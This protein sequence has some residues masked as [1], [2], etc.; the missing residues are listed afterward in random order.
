VDAAPHAPNATLTHAR[1]RT[2]VAAAPAWAW[3]ASLVAVTA[4]VRWGL[5][6]L[7]EMPTFVPDEYIYSSLARSIGTHGTTSIRGAHVTF[8]ALLQ[9][10]LTSPLWAWTSVGTAY[11]LTKALNAVAMASSIVPV[12]LIARSLGLGRRERAVCA[13]FAALSPSLLFVGY[14]IANPYSFP[15]ALWALLAG[16]RVLEAPTVRRQALFLCGAGLAALASI[17]FALLP[18]VVLVAA[19]VVERGRPRAL[20]AWW[21]T[22]AVL[23]AGAAVVLPRQGSVL[24]YYSNASHAGATLGAHAWGHWMFVNAYLL[25]L[26]AGVAVVPG[27][28]AGVVD[29]VVRGHDR[30]ARA[31]GALFCS[32]VAIL[33]TE[34]ATSEHGSGGR[35]AER[36]LIVVPALVVPAFLLWARRGFPLRALAAAVA[37]LVLGVLPY[38]PLIGYVGG[39]AGQDS[40]LLRAVSYV[41]TVAPGDGSALLAAAASLLLLIGGLVVA[42]PGRT[43]AAVALA[44]S[45]ACTGAV[46]A[47]S[48]VLTARSTHALRAGSGDLGWIDRSGLRHVA[49][50][51][52]DGTAAYESMFAFLWN[53]HAL[54]REL[55]LGRGTRSDAFAATRLVAG[56][57]G[58]LLEHGRPLGTPFVVS[59]RA[60]RIGFAG[61]V[62]RV[63]RN[64]DL[65]LWQAHGTPRVRYLAEGWWDNGRQGSHGR[66]VVW[67]GRTGSTL[68][69][70]FTADPARGEAIELSGAGG[71]ETLALRSGQRRTLTFHLRPSD[72][73][74]TL[75]LHVTRGV[76]FD[77]RAFVGG[78][79]APPVLVPDR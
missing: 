15:L 67:P 55:L 14:V 75:R 44:A 21:P 5:S 39:T 28:V 43:T 58:V 20:L 63:G 52:T 2:R 78:F 38:Q 16:L 10:L 45:L 12:V 30:R 32:L 65:T 50:V 13:L 68:L 11:A 72:R 46:S 48:L 3:I 70:S 9:P 23:A 22:A 18:I 69:L 8:P 31:F 40:P 62:R 49:V 53:P 66:L 19:V 79:V 56:R 51:S 25:T 17:Q 34:A 1:L 59:G 76:F 54:D 26:A 33:F 41:E 42:R 71:S 64:G 7:Q 74:L 6:L 37:V 35:F 57:D 4:G 47:G 73:A 27:A 36:Y 29:A 61:G 77:G 60:T 24:G